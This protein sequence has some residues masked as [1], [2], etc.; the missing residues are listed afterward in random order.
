MLDIDITKN[1]FT[2]DEVD[3]MIDVLD[4]AQKITDDAALFRMCQRRM[5]GKVKEIKSLDDLRSK[6]VEKSIE[7][8]D[9]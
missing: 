7:G 8:N 2:E 4:L 5:K 1:E 3:E 6:Y 9:D